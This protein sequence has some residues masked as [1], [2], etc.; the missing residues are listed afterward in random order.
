MDQLLFTRR[1]FL[2][3][4]LLGTGS[5]M[6]FGLGDI[7]TFTPEIVSAVNTF[8]M[9][10][11]DEI[12]LGETYY[13]QYI[14]QSGGVFKNGDAQKIIK[15]FSK[16]LIGAAK[17]NAFPWEIVVVND[18]NVNAW[19]LPGGKIAINSG[20][21][22]KTNTPEELS[23]VIAH[24]IGHA[25]LGHGLSQIKTKSFLSTL[26]ST[27][28]KA[29]MQFGGSYGALGAQAISALEG[30]LFHLIT[31]GYSRENEFEADK[32][33]LYIF[34]KNLINP[35]LADDFFET[36][37]K[38]YP[39]KSTE[40]TSL[41]STHPGTRDRINAIKKEANRQKYSFKEQSKEQFKE[42]KSIVSV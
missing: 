13:N 34:Q 8:T 37:D 27:G 15:D 39:S 7:A 40:T 3:N 28:K 24:E 1:A 26:S 20:L 33:I 18:K 2:I 17:K 23:S 14:D 12:K 9:D 11:K 5:L 16:P 30:P 4:T 41:F 38:L 6:A 31:T 21:I 35:S 10:E 25:D 29:L 19:A 22:Q 42:L 36:L 32:H